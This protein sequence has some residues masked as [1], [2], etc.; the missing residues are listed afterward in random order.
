MKIKKLKFKICDT[1]INRNII[2]A[3][4]KMEDRL[5]PIFE[6]LI[7]N[8][9]KYVVNVSQTEYKKNADVTILNKNT[10]FVYYHKI[11]AP[12]NGFSVLELFYGS[13]FN[14]VLDNNQNLHLI[15]THEGRRMKFSCEKQTNGSVIFV[16]PKDYDQIAFVA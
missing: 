6:T 5:Y 15:F 11:K 14:I 1:F 16:K 7:T 13:S 12:S 10:N 2:N 4:T 8:C 3:I 9:G